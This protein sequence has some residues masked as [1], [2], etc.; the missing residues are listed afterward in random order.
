MPATPLP[1]APPQ[2]M[3]SWTETVHQRE[4]IEQQSVRFPLRANGSGALSWVHFGDLHIQQEQ[5]EN[6]RRQLEDQPAS[7]LAVIND[8]FPSDY[9]LITDRNSSRHVLRQVDIENTVGPW[10][11]KGV[12]GTQLG[13]NE[14]GGKGPW[15]SWRSR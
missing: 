1:A 10:P 6:F 7:Q 5:D 13:P 3:K 14:N 2:F 9:P 15:P 8:H 12:L 4:E 11:E